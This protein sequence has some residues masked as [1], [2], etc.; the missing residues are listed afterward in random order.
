MRR[1]FDSVDIIDL[2]G[3]SRGARPA[4]IETDENVFQVQ[5]GVCILIA[6][7]TGQSRRA[8]A[9]ARVGYA[10]IWQHGGFTAQEKEALLDAATIDALRI[11]F[12]SSRIP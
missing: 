9:E 6:T 1:R 4:G 5:V 2:R 8:G 7:A 3:D 12:M 11:Y 10:D